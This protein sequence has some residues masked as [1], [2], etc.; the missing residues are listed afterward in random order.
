MARQLRALLP[1]ARLLGVEIDEAILDL[2]RRHMDL[3]GTGAEIV[4]GDAYRYLEE[5]EERFDV[6][7]DDLFL[8]GE[9]D[10]KRA[11][12]PA[13]DA[14]ERMRGRLRDGGI[15]VANLIFDCGHFSVRRQARRAFKAAFLSVRVVRP[16][17]GLNEVLVGKEA[18]AP[19]RSVREAGMR[20]FEPHDRA[21][22]GRIELSALRQR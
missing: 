20:F 17:R 6:I 22:W 2:A 11:G 9:H 21:L 18:L 19:P 16:P 4:V 1:K 14:L 8:T 15:V 7:V 3:D 12:P 13:G 10:V 5:T